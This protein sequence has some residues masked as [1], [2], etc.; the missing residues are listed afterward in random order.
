[1]KGN[2][3]AHRGFLKEEWDMATRLVVEKPSQVAE[4]CRA[5]TS[6]K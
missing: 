4:I 5:L 6:C 2:A 3:T 1:M